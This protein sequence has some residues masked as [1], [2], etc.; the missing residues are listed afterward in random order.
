MSAKRLVGL[1]AV[2]LTI[3][4]CARLLGGG[5]T[6]VQGR[7]LASG[8][9]RIGALA[10]LRLLKTELSSFQEATTPS[11]R[12]VVKAVVP[13]TVILGVDL[14]LMKV[15]EAGNQVVIVM[16]QARVLDHSTDHRRWQIWEEHGDEAGVDLQRVLTAQ[17]I[18][19]ADADI[20]RLRLLDKAQAEAEKAVIE[21]AHAMGYARDRIKILSRSSGV[22]EL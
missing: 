14:R 7:T 18:N 12:G 4:I 8:L 3:G 1:L 22:R 6:H 19:A 9:E 21:M 20:L 16:P 17:A 2:G 5:G 15:L 10:E 11:G 13:V